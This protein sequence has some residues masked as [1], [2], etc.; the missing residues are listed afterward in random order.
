MQDF[1]D[2]SLYGLEKLWAFHHYT[3]FPPG[4]D[5]QMQPTV[6]ERGVPAWHAASLARLYRPCLTSNSHGTASAC[7]HGGG[8]CGHASLQGAGARLCVKLCVAQLAG[9]A[10]RPGGV[11]CGVAGGVGGGGAASH[12]H[13]PQESLGC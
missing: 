10:L 13:T 9:P 7:G 5:I 1:E 3:G 2:G 4:E 8:S 6:R 12:A 11:A